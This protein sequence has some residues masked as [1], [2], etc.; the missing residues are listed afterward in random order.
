MN[1]PGIYNSSGGGGSSRELEIPDEGVEGKFRFCDYVAWQI[2]KRYK[3]APRCELYWPEAKRDKAV[4]ACTKFLRQYGEHLF[5]HPTSLLPGKPASLNDV[6]EGRA[7]FSLEGEGETR[8]VAGLKLPHDA[9]WITLENQPSER[10][11]TELRTGKKTIIKGFEQDGKVVQAEEVLKDGKW[12]RFY[13]FAGS[14]HLARVPAKDIELIPNEVGSYPNS[15]NWVARGSGYQA[16]LNG[17]PLNVELY[18]QLPPRLSAETAL[19]IS[20]IMRN[21]SGLHQTSLLAEKSMRLR[22]LYS[23]EYVSPHGTLAPKATR[24][25]GW[26]E[27]PSNLHAQLTTERTQMLAPTKE[28]QVASLDLRKWY[29]LSR[30]GFYRLQLLPINKQP[31]TS[32]EG[33]SEMRFSQAPKSK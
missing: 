11:K 20:I 1:L 16:A 9:R 18:E 4:A 27:V 6:G 24:E 12:Q 5:E 7:I 28:L 2:G 30:S 21:V 29:D 17:P 23:E 15:Y 8:V 32:A 25:A 33:Y 3:A 31:D 19:P 26:Q 14:N 13:G 10:E 22:L